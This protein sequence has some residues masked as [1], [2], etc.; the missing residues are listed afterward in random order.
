MFQGDALAPST[1]ARVGR[2]LHA[3]TTAVITGRRSR[4]A[5]SFEA[6]RPGGH[7]DEV[8]VG[9]ADAQT[10]PPRRRPSSRPAPA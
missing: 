9:Q 6:L 1:A 3:S 2:G 4:V 10:V 8:V 7:P 5:A